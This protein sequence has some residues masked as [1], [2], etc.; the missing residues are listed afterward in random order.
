MWIASLNAVALRQPT[1]LR[2]EGNWEL[3]LRVKKKVIA[4]CHYSLKLGY[5]N[6]TD[7]ISHRKLQYTY[8]HSFKQTL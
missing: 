6:T 5:W 2:Q 8:V 7:V 3:K 1:F 4:Y